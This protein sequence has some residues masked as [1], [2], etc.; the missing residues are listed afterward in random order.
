[1][2]KRRKTRYYHIRVETSKGIYTGDYKA[3]SYRIAKGKAVSELRKRGII[4]RR[5]ALRR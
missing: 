4:K 1:M 2:S 5:K 3:E